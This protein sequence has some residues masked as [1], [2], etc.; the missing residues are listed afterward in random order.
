MAIIF[1]LA[2]SDFI[3]NV[4]AHFLVEYIFMGQRLPK[5]LATLKCCPIT[6]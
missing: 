5:I 4:L 1:D 3:E 2:V 6:P